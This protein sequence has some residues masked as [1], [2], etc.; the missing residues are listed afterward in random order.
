MVDLLSF[1]FRLLVF[2]LY[3]LAVGHFHGLVP[4][5]FQGWEI[6]DDRG[7]RVHGRLAGEVGRDFSEDGP[8]LHRRVGAIGV[9]EAPVRS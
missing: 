3:S 1:R 5:R 8:D 9:A 2:G 4:D 6:H 7:S